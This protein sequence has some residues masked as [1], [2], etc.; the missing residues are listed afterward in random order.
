MD[1]RGQAKACVQQ[2]LHKQDSKLQSPAQWASEW[3]VMGQQTTVRS[4]PPRCSL[5]FDSEQGFIL[6]H[7]SDTSPGRAR[8]TGRAAAFS[9]SLSPPD[10]SSYERPHPPIKFHLG[11]QKTTIAG[12]S[13]FLIKHSQ[14]EYRLMPLSKKVFKAHRPARARHSKLTLPGRLLSTGVSCINNT[15]DHV[16][17][18]IISNTI[19]I[20]QHARTLHYAFV[21][22]TML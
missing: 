16:R 8:W 20:R 11:F 13:T 21:S 19:H 12:K 15:L 18:N 4:H 22:S 5:P 3:L 14:R 10:G 2:F 7:K 6:V 9:M 1:R 17:N